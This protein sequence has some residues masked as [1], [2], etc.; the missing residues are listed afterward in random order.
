MSNG[1]I[2]AL[3]NPPLTRIDAVFAVFGQEVE[4]GV[5]W[6]VVESARVQDKT[7][8]VSPTSGLAAQPKL[9]GN[10][11]SSLRT[12]NPSVCALGREITSSNPETPGRELALEAGKLFGGGNCCKIPEIGARLIRC[13]SSDR[14]VKREPRI[15]NDIVATSVAPKLLSI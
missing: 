6:E 1:E 10:S 14:I 3:N 12:I 13:R 8:L 4:F 5:A 2:A 11:L 9:I 7:V 15:S